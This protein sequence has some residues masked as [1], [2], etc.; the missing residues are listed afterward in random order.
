[1]SEWITDRVPD[2]DRRVLICTEKDIYFGK[3]SNGNWYKINKNIY[4]ISC[5]KGWQELPERISSDIQKASVDYPFCIRL[6]AMLSLKISQ[7]VEYVG[8]ESE[9]INRVNECLN[10]LTERE[11]QVLIMRC[12]YLWSLSTC[13]KNK[14]VTRE[15]I[16]QI[17]AKALRKLRSSCFD[18]I[19]K[20]KPISNT[21]ETKNG[22]E[23]Y[24]ETLGLSTR[25][26]NC[27]KRAGY[28]TL[29]DISELNAH[30]IFRLRNA[31]VKTA[32]EIM[33]AITKL[34]TG[35]KNELQADIRD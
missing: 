34:T 31:G 11:K 35:A 14:G 3:Y 12:M 23:K 22:E 25:A 29:E 1:M 30:D 5:I 4:R 2:T 9:L 8:N 21:T 7:K 10:M 16:R 27:L 19:L 15:R 18:Y 28:N 32:M 6:I 13:G 20:G 24:I 17:E 26:Y 33:S